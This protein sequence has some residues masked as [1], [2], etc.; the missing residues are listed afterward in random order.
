VGVRVDENTRLGGLEA[1]VLVRRSLHLE[2]VTARSEGRTLRR[3]RET[4]E[5]STSR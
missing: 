4:Q 3:C 2:Q 5:S 1:H